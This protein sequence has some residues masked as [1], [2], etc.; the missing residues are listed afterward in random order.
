M[1]KQ[2]G[3]ATASSPG[4]PVHYEQ[5]VRPCH[6]GGPASWQPGTA[7]SEDLPPPP[8]APPRAKTPKKKKGTKAPKAADDMGAWIY[9]LG[10]S[11]SSLQA[12]TNDSPVLHQLAHPG[13]CLLVVYR[14]TR[15]R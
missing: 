4:T 1:S 2:S 8:K 9:I 13:E 5:T 10:A 12:G 7:E 14:C 11:R 6:G 15:T 3:P